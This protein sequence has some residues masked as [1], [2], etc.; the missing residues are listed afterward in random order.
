MVSLN[1]SESRS[2]PGFFQ[3]YWVTRPS[4]WK[5]LDWHEHLQVLPLPDSG[6]TALNQA[7][8]RLASGKSCVFL[9][10]LKKLGFQSKIRGLHKA[11][12]S[13]QCWKR[14]G[15]APKWKEKHTWKLQKLP[16]GGM[17]PHGWPQERGLLWSWHPVEGGDI[18]FPSDIA[19][20]K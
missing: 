4:I 16:P 11:L 20:T 12:F 19:V 18:G 13:Q 9:L 7:Q 3:S 17:S 10:Q 5:D 8:Q 15:V 1:I 6:K 14:F 2:R